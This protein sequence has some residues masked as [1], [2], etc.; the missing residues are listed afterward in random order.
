MNWHKV[1]LSNP[2]V[3]RKM[4]DEATEGREIKEDG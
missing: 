3:T 2:N 1:K 4:V